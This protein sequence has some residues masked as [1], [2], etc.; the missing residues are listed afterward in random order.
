VHPRVREALLYFLKN[1]YSENKDTEESFFLGNPSSIHFFG[2]A[3]QKTIREAEDKIL[4]FFKTSLQKHRVHFTSSGT[5]ANQTV[6]YSCLNEFKKNP[7][8]NQMITSVA[9]HSATL[10]FLPYFQEAGMEVVLVPLLKS[11]EL[12]YSFLEN[13]VSKKTALISLLWANNET[14]VIHNVKKIQEMKEAHECALHLDA[15]QVIGKTNIDLDQISVDYL[16]LSGH[17]IGALAGSGMVLVKDKNPFHT[18][19][20]QGTQ[21][22]LGI[23]A[24][25]CAFL[26][27]NAGEFQEKLLIVQKKF[28]SR[29]KQE[30]PQ[31]LING[32]SCLRLPHTTHLS[33]PLLKSDTLVMDL[34][35]MG[36]SVSA[37]SACQS[38]SLRPSH[39]LTAMGIDEKTSKRSIRVSYSLSTP[40]H[41]LD[42]FIEALKKLR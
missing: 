35:L 10:S 6:L 23:V 4:A 2:R 39:V 29:L 15:A 37:G 36:F 30:I 11:G 21:N 31:A 26:E 14:G 27:L 5:M 25:G 3:A 8:K 33:L 7:K 41:V 19:H 18:F 20:K 42:E 16:T 34:D 40:M 9:E 17:K 13:A 1:S 28:E 12:D 32:E 38:G 22:I 24:L